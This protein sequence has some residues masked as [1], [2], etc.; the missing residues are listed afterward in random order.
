MRKYILPAAALAVVAGLTSLAYVN[1]MFNKDIT[2]SFAPA[3]VAMPKILLLPAAVGECQRRRV[4]DDFGG[5]I[6]NIDLV[7]GKTKVVVFKRL[8]LIHSETTYYPSSS[9]RTNCES[10]AK[11]GPVTVS[12]HGPVYTAI[13]RDA[14]GFKP[15]RERKYDLDGKLVSAG[16]LIEDGSK[17]QTDFF[18]TAGLTTRSETYNLTSNSVESETLYRPDGT[19]LVRQALKPSETDFKRE[20]FSADGQVVVSKESRSYG[21]YSISEMYAN[22]KPRVDASRGQGYTSLKFYRQSGTEEL[23]VHLWSDRSITFKHYNED[24]KPYLETRWVESK[25]GPV[26]GKGYRPLN[27]VK[28]IE[29]NEAGRHIREFNIRPDGTIEKV[30]LYKNDEYLKGRIEYAFNKQGQVVSY[31]ARDE[32]GEQLPEVI[33]AP[34]SGPNFTVPASHQVLTQFS[35]PA[36]IDKY[37]DKIAT[38]VYHGGH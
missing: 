22:G 1:G 13:E 19:A 2:V 4:L 30:T 21:N 7:D 20:H 25:S 29:T 12:Q 11:D 24:G 34:G 33:V 18:S 17:F 6:D 27:L 8:P 16:N 15:V 23:Q 9:D 10:F 32:E 28:F 38:E 3:E 5:A 36:G 37:D 35:I 14:T 26:D 31:K